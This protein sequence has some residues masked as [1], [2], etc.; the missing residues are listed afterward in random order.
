MLKQKCRSIAHK[1][2]AIL[3]DMLYFNYYYRKSIIEK[4]VLIEASHGKV[5]EGNMFYIAKELSENYPD[6]SIFVSVTTRS[7]KNVEK[8]I[9]KYNLTKITLVV[10]GSPKYLE[11]LASVK[12]LFNDTTFLPYFVKKNGQVYLNTWHG[13]PLKALG[14]DMLSESRHLLGNIKRNLIFSDYIV[15]PSKEMQ[16]KFFEAYG[17][18]NLYKGKV[19]N[20][21]YPRNAIFFD[22][23]KEQV[24]RKEL[25]LEDKNIV[26]YMPTWRSHETQEEE[27]SYLEEITNNLKYIDM[28]LT[29]RDVFLIKMHVLA[30]SGL[31][32]S[33]FK[34]I[35]SFPLGYE[36]YEVLNTADT[37]ITDYSSVLFDFANTKRKII[38]FAND[39]EEYTLSRG[40]YYSMDE[41]P[42]PKVDKVEDLMLELRK[43]KAYEDADFL[44]KFC[45]G[46]NMNVSRDLL[47]Y[48]LLGKK[49]DSIEVS[50]VEGNGKPNT[51]MYVASLPMNGITSAVLA[52]L[53]TVDRSKENFYLGFQPL[54][55]PDPALRLSKLPADSL[56][57]PLEGKFRYSAL[58][59][60]ASVLFF[61][62]NIDSVFT[63]KYLDRMYE[64][65]A[66][67]F[68]GG[69]QFDRVVNFVGYGRNMISL[70][71]RMKSDTTRTAI[72]VHSNM[73][74]EAK[75]R[76]TQH[77]PTLKSAYNNYDK[78]V[79]VS[80]AMAAPTREIAATGDNI[81][82]VNNALDY[83]RI[84]DMAARDVYFDK[85]TTSNIDEPTFKAVLDSDCVKFISVGR[86]SPEKGYKRLVDAYERFYQ[87]C[88]NS[89]LILI[90][91]R[92]DYESILQ[93]TSKLSCKDRV[94]VV[95]GLSNPF[96]VVKRCDLFILPS[97]YEAFSMALWEASIL[98]IPAV[99][100]DIPGVREFMLENKGF[101]VENSEDGLLIGMESFA[102]GKVGVMKFDA[103]SHN[104][105]VRQQYEAIYQG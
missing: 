103:E 60:I 88:K 56:V 82:L 2:R 52:L 104:E 89:Y 49:T 18:Q 50:E 26:V 57:F 96:A 42:F 28:H 92:G 81:V 54:I 33:D 64:R 58:E 79:V 44:T 95:K 47:R 63:R 4:T 13:T 3:R 69:A 37:L 59:L 39:F 6:Y 24:T 100:V 11:V 101:L 20:A 12:Y 62:C 31:D 32:F 35:R 16:Q 29:D 77:L 40:T 17:I 76:Q 61:M 85:S 34:H 5:F 86:F 94:I 83:K 23:N 72:F 68:F 84:Q 21:G 73:A 41:L 74:A 14:Y 91:G 19:L 70:L 97:L 93:Q 90:G 22:R 27:K 67:R 8:I 25:G 46:D 45:T 43:E 15:C 10:V 80:E 71:Q 102:A 1:V 9:K 98:G 51:F 7:K 87:E 36:P 53:N 55:M 65:E 30:Q 78:V 66:R 75:L 38:L 105:K 48:L 99:S